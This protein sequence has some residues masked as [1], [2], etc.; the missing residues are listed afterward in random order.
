M[1]SAPASFRTGAAGAGSSHSLVRGA[2]I[3]GWSSPNK[4]PGRPAAF[5]L[6]AGPQTGQKLKLGGDAGHFYL[7]CMEKHN[8]NVD[9]QLNIKGKSAGRHL[10]AFFDG[11]WS[12]PFP[13][14]PKS[15]PRN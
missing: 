14:S 9:P 2:M 3:G 4:V 13:L 5:V 6:P 1:V 8:G 10:K 7:E 12:P 15:F 11:L